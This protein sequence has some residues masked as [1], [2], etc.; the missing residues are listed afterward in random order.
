M[1]GKSR[2][3]NLF[4][5]G[6]ACLMLMSFI[7]VSG[8][9][10][11]NLSKIYRGGDGSALYLR[12]LDNKVY[13]FA[14]HPAQKYAY[15]LTGTRQSDRITAKFRDVPK[16]TRTKFGDVELQFSQAGAK[17]TRKSGSNQMGSDLW[18]EIA[19]GSFQYPPRIAAGFQQTVPGDLD[20]AFVGE[21]GSRHY[22]RELE[23]GELVWV[24]EADTQPGVRPAWVSVFVGKRSATDGISGNYADVPKGLGS[25]KGAF[26]SA[27]IGDKKRRLLALQQTGIS[28]SHKLEPSYAIDWDAFGNSLRQAFDGKAVGFSYAIGRD[29]IVLRSGAG[30][31]RRLS[32]DGQKEKFTVDTFGQ[33]A[34]TTKTITAVALVKALH[35]RQ[36][37]VDSRIAPFLPDCWKKGPDIDKL[38]FRNLLDHTSGLSEPSC[39]EDP[40]ACLVKLVETGSVNSKTFNYNN[41]AY[42]LMRYLVPFVADSAKAKGQFN[43]FKC[44]NGN[45]ELNKD[46]SVMFNRYIF[47]K[48]LAPAGAEASYFPGKNYAMNYNFADQTIEG[49]GPRADFSRRG[50]AGYLAISAPNFVRFIGALDHGILLPESVVQEMYSGDLGFD[51]PSKGAAGTYYTKNGGCPDKEDMGR[52]CGAQVMVF[53]SGIQGYVM[54]NSGSNQ[55]NGNLRNILANAFDS[56]LK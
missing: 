52:G 20:G 39:R 40:Y 1:L 17:I 23:D 5:A 14:E 29:G 21:D 11:Q 9:Y 37:K 8:V 12:V 55:I 25:A 48:V 4:L 19:A 16:G 24:A 50:G 56:S 13:G 54:V 33:A 2:I 10:G 36:I 53:P 22:V 45:D 42:A 18:E 32:V 7:A 46:I 3:Q 27:F 31:F 51:A 35:D 43:L 38:T 34:S 30:G 49:S 6:F 47:D 41:T 28:R 44:K 26:G 15:V